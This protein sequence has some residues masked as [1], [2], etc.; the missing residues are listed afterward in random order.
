VDACPLDLFTI[1]PTDAHLLVQCR[2]LL[3]G[4]DAEAVCAVACNACKRCVQDAAS[5]LIEMKDGLARVNYDMIELENPKAIERCP[6]G[7]IVWLEGRQF[8]T[9][10]GAE[11]AGADAPALAG[12]ATTGSRG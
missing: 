2:N 11:G 6:T 9:L 4:D 8:P 7:A 5:G 1:L 3:E 12:L 10:L